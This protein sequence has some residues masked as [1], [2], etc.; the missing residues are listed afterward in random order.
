[1]RILVD[2]E[3]VPW[4]K[5][6]DIVTRTFGFTNHTVLPEVSSRRTVSPLQITNGPLQIGSR[7]ETSVA[8][9]ES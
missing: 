3:E 5:A 2:E 8:S 6:W 4:D 1:M 9:E 7:G